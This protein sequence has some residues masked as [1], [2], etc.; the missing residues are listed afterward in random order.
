MLPL[1]AFPAVPPTGLLLSLDRTPSALKDDSSWPAVLLRKLL[2]LL[3]PPELCRRCSSR[4]LLLLWLALL[5]LALVIVL[6]L[7]LLFGKAAGRDRRLAVDM[8]IWWYGNNNGTS[9]Q[10]FYRW[11][12]ASCEEAMQHWMA[13]RQQG[14]LSRLG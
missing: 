2:L 8:G 4:M 3:L 5:L 9:E 6:V 14:Y 13:S 12:V 11:S 1:L 10:L 7:V